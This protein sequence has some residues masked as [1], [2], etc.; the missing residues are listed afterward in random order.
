M[1]MKGTTY[2][3]LRPKLAMCNFITDPD[4]LKRFALKNRFDGIDWSFDL[5]H[6]PRGPVEDSRWVKYLSA[7]EPL[8]LRFHCPFM[9]VDIGHE[10]AGEGEKAVGIF[11]RIIPWWYWL[12]TQPKTSGER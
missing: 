6:L 2:P 1:E 8:E 12:K 9:K 4:R 3:A 7:M 5:E 11:R 10:D